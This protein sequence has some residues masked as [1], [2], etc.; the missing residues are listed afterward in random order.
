[1]LKVKTTIDTKILSMNTG[2]NYSVSYLITRYVFQVAKVVTHGVF[3]AKA[4]RICQLT[5]KRLN[6]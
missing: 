1:M 5:E 6:S 4:P 2:N 3:F